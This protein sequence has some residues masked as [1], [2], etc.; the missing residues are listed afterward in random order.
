MTSIWV[1]KRSQL[2]EAGFLEVIRF[3]NVCVHSGNSNGHFPP[4]S[5][6]N[7]SSKGSF[8]IAMLDYQRVYNCSG[9]HMIFDCF[10]H[11]LLRIISSFKRP[12][13]QPAMLVYQRVVYLAKNIDEQFQQV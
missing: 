4:F 6:G 11:P 5:I 1:I 13:F 9:F 2:E 7:I 12:M 3:S 10:G 8:S